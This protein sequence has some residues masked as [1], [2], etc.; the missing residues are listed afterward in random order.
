MQAK[1]MSAAELETI[2][3]RRVGTARQ[4]PRSLS[5]PAVSRTPMSLSQAPSMRATSSRQSHRT[6]SARLLT[7]ASSAASLARAHAD[8]AT[9]QLRRLFAA[10]DSSSD[11]VL[12][13]E[14]LLQYMMSRGFRYAHVRDFALA[15]DANADGG[16][17]HG[18]FSNALQSLQRNA[19]RELALL[20]RPLEHL[21]IAPNY[22]DLVV[23]ALQD[24]KS[25]V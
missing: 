1:D 20:A 16:V 11:G 8:P 14:E 19:P 17:D 22:T 5:S 4:L 23:H 3:I 25:V 9:Q 10:I 13:D 18:E 21:Q 7:P 24:R 12:Q 15:A 6:T 2:G